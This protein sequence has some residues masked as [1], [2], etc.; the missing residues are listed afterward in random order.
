MLCH[1]CSFH[2]ESK[3][4]NHE[5]KKQMSVEL[6][7][8]NGFIIEISYKSEIKSSEEIKKVNKILVAL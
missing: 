6:L 5:T 3:N 8:N 7:K 1:L 4:E 2:L